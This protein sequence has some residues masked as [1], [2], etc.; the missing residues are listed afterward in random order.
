MTVK[1]DMPRVPAGEA[2]LDCIAW[3]R[4]V[5]DAM[6]EAT[7]DLPADEFIAY[8]HRAAVAVDAGTIVRQPT[9]GIRTA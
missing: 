5:R 4:S 9:S 3:V 1:T 6:Y 7:S 2:E 8:V